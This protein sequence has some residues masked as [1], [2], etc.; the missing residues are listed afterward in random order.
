MKIADI[1]GQPDSQSMPAHFFHNALRLHHH[2]AVRGNPN[3]QNYS[4]CPRCWYVDADFRCA[5]C[6]L[7]FTW[8]AGE[9][10]TWFEDHGFWVDSQPRHCLDC[11][12]KSRRMSELRKEYDATVAAA[13]NHGSSGQKRRIIEIVEE[14]EE[15]LDGLPE[16]MIRTKELFASQTASN[17]ELGK[18]DSES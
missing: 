7:D 11:R 8:T 16:K 6:D 4:V 2:T 15:A 12:K 3:K 1:F 14:L 13:R 17:G 10:K 18:F 9:Q 5:N